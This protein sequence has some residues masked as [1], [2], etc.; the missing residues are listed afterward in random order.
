MSA[1]QAHVDSVAI[2]ADVVRD[3]AYWLERVTHR[4]AEA[5]HQPRHRAADPVAELSR[6]RA[7]RSVR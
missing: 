4:P 1:D 7:S 5:D 6:G 2:K 3:F